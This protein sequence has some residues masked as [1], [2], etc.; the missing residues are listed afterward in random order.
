M[1]KILDFVFPPPPKV[2]AEVQ[3]CVERGG[4]VAVPTES[5]YALAASATN[6]AAVHRIRVIKQQP[7]ENPILVLVGDQQVV[8]RLVSEIPAS[9]R[10]LMDQLWPGALTLVM[11]ASPRLPLELTAGTQTVGVRQPGDAR[12]RALLRKVGPLTGTSANRSGTPPAR[13]A[14]AVQQTLG[15]TID[16]ILD[17]GP[18]PGGLPSTL[19]ACGD[20]VRILRHGPITSRQL[21]AVLSPLGIQLVG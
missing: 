15:E 13:T 9:A 21:R 12:L 11:P 19:V 8:S 6:A 17:G 3:A 20:A 4:V 7:S 10:A 2:I 16:L 1:V 14:E 5:F 18:T